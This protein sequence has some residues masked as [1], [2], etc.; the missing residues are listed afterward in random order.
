MYIKFARSTCIFL[1]IHFYAIADE[2]DIFFKTMF[3]SE[4]GSIIKG[5]NLLPLGPNS[6]L[7]Q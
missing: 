6:I 5:R 4:K 1:W 3:V 2:E 7:L